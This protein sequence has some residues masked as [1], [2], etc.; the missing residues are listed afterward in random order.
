M[1]DPASC[2]PPGELERPVAAFQRHAFAAVLGGEAPRITDVVEA[3]SR[4]TPAVA[5][6]IAWLQ[7]HGRLIAQFVGHARPSTTAG[8]VKCL[9]RRPEA[10]ARRAAE[11][12][13]ANA[14]RE[15]PTA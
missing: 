13:D 2:G 12:L 3:A 4:D 6:G 1:T 5:P 10:V 8:Y 14:E 7:E 15:S 11:V 9:G